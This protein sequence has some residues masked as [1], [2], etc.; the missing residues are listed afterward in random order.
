MHIE[1]NIKATGAFTITVVDKDGNIV[2]ERDVKNV[3]VT[4]GKTFLATWL[5]AASQALPFMNYIGIGTGTTGALAA[6]TALETEIARKIAALSSTTNVWQSTTTFGA[7]EGTG[8]I[9]EAAI[10]SQA[11]GGTMLARQTFA[12]VPKGATD[13]LIVTWSV[14]FS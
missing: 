1:N 11:S 13:L 4:A 7:G 3:V 9:S 10:L 8:T 6:D 12:G 14:T 2:A 5:A